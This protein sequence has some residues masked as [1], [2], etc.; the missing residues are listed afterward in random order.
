MQIAK[1]VACAN[2]I[3]YEL[4]DRI[5]NM[6]VAYNTLRFH[7]DTT[8]KYEDMCRQILKICRDAYLK[9]TPPRN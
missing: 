1:D 9:G 5:Y 2:K 8:E 4:D 7:P 3:T 6:L